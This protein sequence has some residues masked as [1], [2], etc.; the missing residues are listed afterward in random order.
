MLRPR[1]F[2]QCLSELKF[3]HNFTAINYRPASAYGALLIGKQQFPRAFTSSVRA[4]HHTAAF[5]HSP[6]L[7]LVVWGLKQ[8]LFRQPTLPSALCNPFASSSRWLHYR[9]KP[10]WP[11]FSS[12]KEGDWGQQGGSVGRGAVCRPNDPS[13]STRGRRKPTPESCLLTSS[14]WLW[15][16]CTRMFCPTTQAIYEKRK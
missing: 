5:L 12:S 4:N 3:S 7:G 1:W 16:V 11:G 14:G 13:S 2:N 6:L 10:P 8:G 9:C 15:F